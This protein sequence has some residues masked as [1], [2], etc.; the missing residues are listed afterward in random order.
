M[1]FFL[2]I[3]FFNWIWLI[4]VVIIINNY[5]VIWYLNNMGN[6]KDVCDNIKDI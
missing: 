2:E 3:F 5:Y 4:I 1:V 6:F